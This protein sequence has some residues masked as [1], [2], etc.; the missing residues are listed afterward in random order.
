MPIPFGTGRIT[1]GLDETSSTI[2][3]TTGLLIDKGISV[4]AGNDEEEAGDENEVQPD[5]V[6]GCENVDGLIKWVDAG[7]DNGDNIM[8]DIDGVT[9]DTTGIDEKDEED[10]KSPTTNEGVAGDVATDDIIDR[11]KGESI[12]DTG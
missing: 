11:D 1:G 3:S 5:L 2:F 10:D 9:D 12:E 7:E 8:D 6:F 4:V